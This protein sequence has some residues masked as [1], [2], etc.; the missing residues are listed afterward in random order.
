MCLHPPFQVRSHSQSDSLEIKNYTKTEVGCYGSS[1]KGVHLNK[2]RSSS[3]VTPR[4]VG[5]E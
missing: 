5:V 1:Q 2:S 3:V 4:S